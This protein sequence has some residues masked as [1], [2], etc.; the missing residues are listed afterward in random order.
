LPIDPD[1]ELSKIKVTFYAHNIFF[2]KVHTKQQ[3]N[4]EK[5]WIAWNLEIMSAKGHTIT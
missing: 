2:N 4:H 5:L 3:K 1:T